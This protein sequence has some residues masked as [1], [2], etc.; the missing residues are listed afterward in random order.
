MKLLKELINE[1]DNNSAFEA[2]V[3]EAARKMKKALGVPKL[4][5]Q[6]KFYPTHT[7]LE[8]DARSVAKENRKAL[9]T[10][11]E[12]YLKSA[13]DKWKLSSWNSQGNVYTYELKRK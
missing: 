6:L 8:V 5:Y 10:K 9:D 7:M 11:I 2:E 13:V 1:Q 12:Q 3:K 4:M